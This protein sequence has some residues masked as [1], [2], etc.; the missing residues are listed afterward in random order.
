MSTSNNLPVKTTTTYSFGAN[1]ALCLFLIL[2][3]ATLFLMLSVT[4]GMGYEQF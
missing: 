4:L 1:S 3:V 2:F